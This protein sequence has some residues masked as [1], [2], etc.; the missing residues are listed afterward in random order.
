MNEDF[1]KIVGI[2][3]II[4]IFIFLAIKLLKVQ[5]KVMEGLT[6]SDE[7]GSSASNSNNNPKNGEAGSA[8]QYASDIENKN[9]KLEDGLLIPKYRTD[10]EQ[11]ILNMDDYINILM[12]K[13][14][15]N[16]NINDDT[17]QGNKPNSNIALFESL[18]VLN[19]AKTSLNNV[20]KFVDKK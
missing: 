19:N 3:V 5:V 18:N 12:L 17:I 10:Y 11:I 2:V 16:I 8:S 9:T 1:L 14:L 13:T 7:S 15:L 6:N 20:M 4:S